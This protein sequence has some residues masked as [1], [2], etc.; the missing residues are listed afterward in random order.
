MANT[1]EKLELSDETV[2]FIVD[3]CR[4]NYELEWNDIESLFDGFEGRELDDGQL[5]VVRSLICDAKRIH[6][7]VKGAIGYDRIVD[8]LEILV[9]M[10]ELV[11]I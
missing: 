3:V 1:Y 10:C 5:D 6:T 4:E 7:C 2:D 8:E 9:D 11:G